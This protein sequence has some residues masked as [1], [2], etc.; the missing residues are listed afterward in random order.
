[1]KTIYVYS[2]LFF[3]INLFSQRKIELSIEDQGFIREAIIS[4]P[5]TPPPSE[6][7]PAVIMFH[8][9]SGDKDVFYNAKGWKE[10]GEEENFITIFPSALK[11][12]YYED[13]IKKNNTKFVCGDL[14]EKICPEDVNTLIDDIAFSKRLL[15]LTNDSFKINAKKIY[16]SGF[17]NGDVMINKLAMDAGQI[18][19]SVGGS[20]GVL[21][22][23]DSITPKKRIPIWYIFGTKDDRFLIEPY[24]E[25]PFGGDS[26]LLYIGKH[27][28]RFLVC[29]G[30]EKKYSSKI[31]TAINKTYVFDEC[32]PGIDCARLLVTVN[33]GQT[34]QF[35]NGINYPFNAPRLL[36]KFFNNELT[37]NI[38]DGSLSNFTIDIYPN[39]STDYFT[40]V[41]NNN[42]KWSLEIID[43]FGNVVE[44][45][46]D[47][48]ES[49]YR[50]SSSDLP[51]A[52]YIIKANIM[53]QTIFKKIVLN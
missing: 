38:K 52:T 49:E 23:L 35:P 25:I 18:F 43:L 48:Y 12:C 50:V 30:L 1:M 31:E 20:S 19:S 53:G 6:G 22:A 28:N 4:V 5:T 40:I 27:L 21:N 32:L 24:T 34:H 2:L 9:T 10:L 44:K 29:Q 26:S 16:A 8:G 39:P 11:W 7:Y 41:S 3:S 37:S 45:I 42:Q 46:S 13:G 17:S 47:I 36:W 33:K 14:I 51:R 15:K